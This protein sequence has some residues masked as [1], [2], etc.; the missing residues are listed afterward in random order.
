MLLT[1]SYR[2][3]TPSVGKPFADRVSVVRLIAMKPRISWPAIASRKTEF[4]SSINPW[5][6]S[7]YGPVL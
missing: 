7:G 2:L 1:A 4:G 3:P 6:V 5:K